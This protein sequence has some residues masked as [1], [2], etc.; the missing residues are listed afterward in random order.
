MNVEIKDKKVYIDMK[1]QVQQSIDWGKERGNTRPPTPSLYT[2]FSTNDEAIA[3]DEEASDSFHSIVQKLLYICKRARPDIEPAISFLCT[4]VSSPNVADNVKLT[5]VLR[6][7]QN[8]IEDRRVIGI[9]NMSWD[10]QVVNDQQCKS[11][12]VLKPHQNK[13]ST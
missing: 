3:L 6:Y 9:N 5:R 13:S 1:D 8:T 11:R 4:R 10:I 7:L 12:S 2:L